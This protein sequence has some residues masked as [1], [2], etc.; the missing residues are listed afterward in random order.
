MIKLIKNVTECLESASDSTENSQDENE[1]VLKQDDTKGER[2]E[3]SC[4]TLI[5]ADQV[6]LGQETAVST[7]TGKTTSRV[8]ITRAP[9]V[10]A[11]INTIGIK[12]MAYFIFLER[13]D[14]YTLFFSIIFKIS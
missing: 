12:F 4:V 13:P 1:T 3:V 10:T 14:D 6:M 7:V 11:E 5:L 8:A 2:E 9:D